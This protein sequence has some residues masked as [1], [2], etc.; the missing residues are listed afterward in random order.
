M[1]ALNNLVPEVP[2][3]LV[4]SYIVG[5][6]KEAG[7]VPELRQET[8]SLYWKNDAG[9]AGWARSK[10]AKSDE[11]AIEI[12]FV[13]HHTFD[14]ALGKH[15]VTIP[16][17]LGLNRGL[18]HGL[19]LVLTYTNKKRDACSLTLFVKEAVYSRGNEMQFEADALGEL[20]L[21]TAGA[22]PQSVN[23]TRMDVI[24]CERIY[25]DAVVRRLNPQ[26]PPVRRAIRNFAHATADA[27]QFLQSMHTK[28]SGINP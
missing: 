3:M 9:Q 28:A 4:L 5:Y 2:A 17:R 19:C 8:L 27:S 18:S 25:M 14:E 24:G 22:K 7:W 6:A 10:D 1:D 26:P 20:T 21:L 11:K 23:P 12:D 13:Y 16:L 15:F